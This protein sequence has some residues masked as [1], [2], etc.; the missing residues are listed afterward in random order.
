MTKYD[1]TTPVG[2]LKKARSVFTKKRHQRGHYFNP[3]DEPTNPTAVCALGALNFAITGN[4]FKIPED[5]RRREVHRKAEH[6]LYNAVAKITGGWYLGI[7]TYSDN[8]K[9]KDVIALFT[10]AIELG[11]AAND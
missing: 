11:E 6:L 1:T 8:S 10:L 5:N 7:V 9:K 4:A 2:L 3:G